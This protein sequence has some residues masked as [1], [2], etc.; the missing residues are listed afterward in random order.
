[1][2]TTHFDKG[3]W[4]GFVTGLGASISDL[5]YAVMT[6]LGMSIVIDFIETNEY[7][8]QILEAL[9]WPD[10]GLI[11]IVKIRKEY[12]ETS[13]NKN[14]FTQDFVTQHSFLH[15]QIVD[16]VSVYRIVRPT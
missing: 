4:S 3:R 6:G 13:A 7:L 16:I 14:T 5:G 11:C 10:S 9:C 12:K 1:M 15:C 8:I 2:H